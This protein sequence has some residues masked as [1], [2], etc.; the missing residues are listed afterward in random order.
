VCEDV[1]HMRRMHACV[2]MLGMVMRAVCCR[3][4]RAEALYV[5]AWTALICTEHM[6]TRKRLVARRVLASAALVLVYLSI[7]LTCV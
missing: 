3:L 2:C 5:C 4:C 6:R 1:T 7:R